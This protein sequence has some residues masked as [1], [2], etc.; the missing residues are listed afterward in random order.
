MASKLNGWTGILKQ[1]FGEPVCS[2]GTFLV[3]GSE[4]GLRSEAQQTKDEI[5]YFYLCSHSNFRKDFSDGV[6]G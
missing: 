6:K 1:S 5:S 4:T 3:P 2:C